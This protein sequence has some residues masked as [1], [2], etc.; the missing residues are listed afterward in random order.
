MTKRTGAAKGVSPIDRDRLDSLSTEELLS[1]LARLRRCEE[2]RE[3]SDMTAAEIAAVDGILFK[4]SPEW[5]Q[6]YE[7]VKSVPS[8][9]EHLPSGAERRQRRTERAKLN[10]TS[11][12]KARRT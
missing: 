12:R 9:R 4:D 1:R 11:E 5:R 10:R 2:N 7:D 6:A 3:G 8:G